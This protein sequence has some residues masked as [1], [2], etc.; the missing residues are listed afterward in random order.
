MTG[1]FADSGFFSGPLGP[2]SSP[3]TFFGPC[4]IGTFVFRASSA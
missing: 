1:P 2:V 4:F 3:S